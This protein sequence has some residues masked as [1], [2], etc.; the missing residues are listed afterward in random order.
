MIG[1]V[2]VQVKP[3]EITEVVK[4]R[5]KKRSFLEGLLAM[6]SPVHLKSI[7]EAR[8]HHKVKRERTRGEVFGK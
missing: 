1:T 8:A 3:E 2:K 4:G 7:R 5:E 6:T